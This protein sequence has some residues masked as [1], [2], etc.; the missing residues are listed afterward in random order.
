MSGVK[1]LQ[2]SDKVDHS[3]VRG[4]TWTTPCGI[5]FEHTAL[6]FARATEGALVTEQGLLYKTVPLNVADT[7][8][9]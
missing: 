5:N 8:I 6:Y 7:S 9:K 3:A 2:H 1:R 4:L